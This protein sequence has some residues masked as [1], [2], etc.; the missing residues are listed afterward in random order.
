MSKHLSTGDPMWFRAIW[1]RQRLRIIT[2]WLF[3]SICLFVVFIHSDSQ[4]YELP[5]GAKLQPPTSSPPYGQWVSRDFWGRISGVYISVRF[6]TASGSYTDTRGYAE[7]FPRPAPGPAEPGYTWKCWP[8][9]N[10]Y[11][12]SVP[13]NKGKCS[14]IA[15]GATEPD[16]AFIPTPLQIRN[17]QDDLRYVLNFNFPST[18]KNLGTCP[19]TTIGNPINTATG[20]KYQTETD[21]TAGPDTGLEFRRF[22]NSQGRGSSGLGALWRST[23]SRSIIRL[24]DTVAKAVSADCQ[25]DT[26]NLVGGAWKAD[27]DVTSRLAPVIDAS[28]HQTGWKLTKANDDTEFYSFAEGR[29]ELVVSRSGRTTSLSY[30]LYN[31]LTSV[32][33]PFGQTIT[34]TPGYNL[35]T[36]SLTAPDGH[37]YSYTYDTSN[38]L[39]SVTYPD[40]KVRQYLYENVDFPHALTGII[41]EKGVRFATFAYDDDGKAITTE[42]AGGVEK[43]TVAYNVDGSSTV[44]DALGRKYT[45][46][47]TTQFDLIK[48]TSVTGAC[49]GCDV[50]AYTYDAKGFIAST[51][52]FNGNKTT[53]LHDARGLETS[54]TE[55]AGTAL[56]RTITTMWHP[57]FHLPTKIIEPGRTTTLVY[58]T[59]GNLL[60]RTITAGTVGALSRTW[61]YTYNSL[62]QV[63]TV[64]GP[65]TDVPDVTTFTYDVQGNLSTVTNPLGQI[66]AFTSYD[67][68]G[69]PLS[70]TAPNGIVTT[71]A[72]DPRGRLSSQTEGTEKTQY[73]HDAVGNLTKVTLP[74]GSSLTYSY[75]A[76]HRLIGIKDALGNRITYTLDK[77]GNRKKENVRD[78]A[79]ALARTTSR[80]Y[81]ALNRPIKAIGATGQTTSFAYDANDNLIKITDPLSRVTARAFDAL[82]RLIE[83]TDPAAGKTGYG[84]DVLDR[85]T[86]VTDPKGLATVYAYDGLD[87]Q[88]QTSSPDTGLTTKTYDTAGNVLSATDARGQKTT[89]TYDKLNRLTKATFADGKTITY[90]YD[91]G[92]NGVGK[93]TTLTDASGS[94]R[95]VYDAHG[96]V[97]TR[98]QIAGATTLTTSYAYDAAGRLAAMAYPSGRTVGYAYDAAG[99]VSA[100]SLDGQ[101]LLSQIKYRPFGP[102]A[103]WVWKNGTAYTRHFDS[104][105][106]VVELPL[107]NDTRALTYDAAGRITGLTDAGGAQTFGYDAL[108]RLTAYTAGATAQAYSYDADGNR[109]TLTAGT[110]NSAYNYPAGNN[111][112]LARTGSTPKTYTYDNTGN[113]V[114]DGSR[115]F[116]YDAR[117]RM[118][119]ATVGAAATTYAING[120]GQ[121]VAKSG[122]G[123]ATGLN[124]FVYDE[125]GNLVG[126][127]DAAGKPIKETVWF[128]G[129]PVAVATPAAFF[130]VFADH[131]GTPRVITNQANGV[132]WNWKSDPFGNGKPTGSLTY[133]LRF[134]GQYYDKETGL[135][136]NYFR[137]YDPTTGRYVQSDPIGLGG[138]VNTYGYAGANPVMRIDQ[139]GLDC[140]SED[141]VRSAVQKVVEVA[142]EAGNQAAKKVSEVWSAVDKALGVSDFAQE[143]QNISYQQN[144]GALQRAE[145]FY[146]TAQG[147]ELLDQQA[148]LFGYPSWQATDNVTKRWLITKTDLSHVIGNTQHV[149]DATREAG[150]SGTGLIY[151]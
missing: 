87:N 82:N 141:P 96:R 20:N 23:Y 70:M 61:R 117:R 97:L 27:P 45:T 105:G 92:A 142:G 146:N 6:Y 89:Y 98:T 16:G 55:A 125:A 19:A 78:P 88:L 124:R 128:A 122:G 131:L 104:D 54:R 15:S 7:V 31:E 115:A 52:D 44:T 8:A 144:E 118:A 33:G 102:P 60:R 76:A 68:A 86:G 149:I 59:K 143:L 113:L 136:Y 151:E 22:Y 84:Y 2:K 42:H 80:V 138:G 85:L 58:D 148:Q 39:T 49:A 34:F 106:R 145:S 140:E 29:L 36:A 40:G 120:L 17:A 37:V 63:L 109:L 14:W 99:Q 116:A 56:A 123:I 101:P 26:F 53:Y 46:A 147:K 25:I 67:G 132:V 1:G 94:L 79:N 135:H 93:L 127:Y 111:W 81:D 47:L 30:D 112:L 24:T 126:E 75:D 108:D 43:N 9:I 72:Y 18:L 4:G 130:N 12:Y 137:D 51:T 62:G 32:T 73:T 57:Q 50:K 41:D 13:Y 69:R 74:D 114:G 66:T 21:F 100:L 71:F 83:T 129:A 38:N 65:R 90:T 107:G 5:P 95:W 64:N 139:L 121:R 134:P 150:K 103:S 91:Q 48:P 11:I 110:A 10:I 133:N 28:G 3:L 35:N 77:V 119:K